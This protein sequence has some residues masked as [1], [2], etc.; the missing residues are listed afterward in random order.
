MMKLELDEFINEGLKEGF[1]P[2]YIYKIMVNQVLVGTLV[3]RLGSDE[4]HQYDGH[5][6]YTIDEIHRGHHYAYQACLLLR[7]MI[8]KAGYD[9]VIITCDPANIASQKTILALGGEYQRTLP[10][11]SSHKKFFT[12]Q[13]NEKEVYIWRMH[14]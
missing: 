10:I 4:E 8:R 13:E 14:A 7:K 3:F 9:H 11:P 5:I 1:T 6:A 2:F 12:P